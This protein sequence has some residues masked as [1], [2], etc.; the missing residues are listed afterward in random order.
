MKASYLAGVL[1]TELIKVDKKT[2]ASTISLIM[3]RHINIANITDKI[4]P[5]LSESMILL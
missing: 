5:F 2:S 3:L 1:S 4:L